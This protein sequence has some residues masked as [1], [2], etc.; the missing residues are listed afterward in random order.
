MNRDENLL[1]HVLEIRVANTEISENS[2]NVG[3]V[4]IEDL[5]RREAKVRH[6]AA[7]S[8]SLAQPFT[9]ACSM[10]VRGRGPRQII[11]V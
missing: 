8:A 4:F 5:S 10:A 9:D 6:S 2:E 7:R 3:G 11:I 1:A